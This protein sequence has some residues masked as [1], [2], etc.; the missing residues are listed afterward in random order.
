MTCPGSYVK[1][2]IT[3]YADNVLIYCKTHYKADQDILHQDLS[4]HVWASTCFLHKRATLCALEDYKQTAPSHLFLLYEQYSKLI[5][6]N[7]LE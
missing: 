5:M 3:L 4:S 6:L 7:T 1:S 2:I